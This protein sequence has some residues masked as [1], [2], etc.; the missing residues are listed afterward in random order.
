MFGYAW[1]NRN[2]G[3]RPIIEEPQL[4]TRG[5]YKGTWWVRSPAIRRR[6]RTDTVHLTDG[7]VL[8]F[9]K[10]KRGKKKK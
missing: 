3:W 1:H 7:T 5:R 2:G 9:R 10:K 6:W 8:R 4:I